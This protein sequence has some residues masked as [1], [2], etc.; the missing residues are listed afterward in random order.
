M[1]PLVEEFLDY[2]VVEKGLA[3]NSVEAYRRDLVKFEGFL[4]TRCNF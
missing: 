1:Q 4:K 2:I 3:K